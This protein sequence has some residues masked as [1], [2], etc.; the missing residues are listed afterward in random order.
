MPRTT[1][2]TEDITDDAVTAPKIASGA[3]PEY[4]DS[5]IQDDIALIGLR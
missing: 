4:D 1:I 5:G 3:V 2:R